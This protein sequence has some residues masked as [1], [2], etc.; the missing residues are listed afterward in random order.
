MFNKN[1]CGE[2]EYKAIPRIK[3]KSRIEMNFDCKS[4]K[5]KKPL[6]TLESPLPLLKSEPTSTLIPMK[7]SKDM[8]HPSKTPECEDD[9]DNSYESFSHMT[10]PEDK[11][12]DLLLQIDSFRSVLE[13]YQIYLASISTTS[14]KA[15]QELRKQFEEEYNKLQSA[16]ESFKSVIERRK[17]GIAREL[18]RGSLEEQQALLAENKDIAPRLREV[19]RIQAEI[20]K[21]SEAG[22]QV[23]EN[24]HSDQQAEFSSLKTRLFDL[25][26]ELEKVIKFK[27]KKTVRSR[28]I[29]CDSD[30]LPNAANAFQLHKAP[31]A[32]SLQANKT[33]IWSMYEQ[34]KEIKKPMLI[35]LKSQLEPIPYCKVWKYNTSM[36][37]ISRHKVAL[38]LDFEFENALSIMHPNGAYFYLFSGGVLLQYDGLND[39]FLKKPVNFACLGTRRTAIVMLEHYIYILGGFKDGRTVP[40]TYKFNTITDKWTALPSMNVERHSAGGSVVD[41]STICVCGGENERA[42]A[43]NSI[44]VYNVRE[45][46]WKVCKVAMSV[47]RKELC[48]AS[49]EKGK[50]IIIGGASSRDKLIEETEEI[51]LEHNSVKS[52]AGSKRSRRNA[53]LFTLGEK[54]LVLGGSNKVGG[55]GER[56]NYDSGE[57]SYMNLNVSEEGSL[58]FGM[59]FTY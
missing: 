58:V 26:N 39:V 37:L 52:L 49:L 20:L 38:P 55:I 3:V 36:E 57:W 4:K 31:S 10:V 22:K 51:D 25:A 11:A 6:L 42:R 17:E 9:L 45:N 12:T 35:L 8:I 18:L 19:A 24:K 44:E 15:I 47:S 1:L 53:R 50:V 46:M 32:I 23:E 7:E 56:Y 48:V 40:N 13:L 34:L 28:S 54:I 41:E 29:L 5:A 43:L 16:T 30:A 21:T 2:W 33:E 14:Q 59:L 27:S